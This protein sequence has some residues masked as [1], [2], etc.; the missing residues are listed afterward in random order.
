VKQLQGFE[1]VQEFYDSTNARRFYQL[2][3]YF[4]KELGAKWPELLDRL[5]GGGAVLANLK[6]EAKDPAPALMVIQSK[7]E[8]LLR[9]FVDVAVKLVE[10]EQ[11]RNEAKDRLQRAKYRDID[12]YQAGKDVHAAVL[13]SA[14]V[15][16]ITEKAFHDAIDR[17]LDGGKSSLANAPRVAEARKLLPADAFAW[18]WLN[19]EHVRKLPGSKEA[20]NAEATDP[21]QTILFGGWLDQFRRTPFLAAALA[22]SDQGFVL[23]VRTPI[24]REGMN[25]GLAALHLP[26]ADQ[27][28]TLPLLE[29]KGV[30]FSMSYMLDFHQFWEQRAKIL[31]AE[32]VKG[33]EEV[34]RQ[35]GKVLG[36]NKL[37]WL[38]TAAGAQQRFVAAQP[39]RGGY[40]TKAGQPIPAFASILS[41]RDPK[42]FAPAIETALR[43]AALG[44]L[45]AAKMKLVE[46]KHGDLTIVG[47]R[48]PEDDD[49]LE[50]AVGDVRFN[51]APCFVSVGNQFVISSTFELAHD[52]IDI[53]KQEAK[54]D[55]KKD[56]TAMQ[57]RFYPSGAADYLQATEE[58]L[59]AATV[60]DRA[61]APK[62]AKEEVKKFIELVRKSGAVQIDQEYGAKDFRFDIRLTPGK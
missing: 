55:V 8:A 10:A 59:L 45:A 21:P 16:G 20:L 61:L 58:Q 13:G 50:V 7:D 23:T 62:E 31:N 54:G 24:G 4:E 48:F 29:P 33:L 17:H 37:S 1:A 52:L 43:T 12:I 19:V 42:T 34:D 26:S 60:L 40:K 49:S 53:L 14:L 28:G 38:M 44:G 22:P 3:A 47:W 15:I 36:G 32:Q 6:L 30:L 25:K 9:R 18:L 5:A 46:E 56:A 39:S 2:I 11:A 51:F 41:M 27:G 57:M 35:S